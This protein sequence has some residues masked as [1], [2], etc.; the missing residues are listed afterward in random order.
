MNDQI[1]IIPTINQN[2]SNAVLEASKGKN[3]KVPPNVMMMVFLLLLEAEN[4]SSHSAAIQAK[5]LENNAFAQQRLNA[6][7]EKVQ[8]N[9]IP[10]EG[11]VYRTVRMTHWGPGGTYW[12]FK[13]VSVPG[14]YVN[15]TAVAEAEMKNQELMSMREKISNELI[16]LQQNS[17]VDTV[18]VNDQIQLTIMTIRKGSYIL[19]ILD[20]L[21]FKMLL[22][23]P[24]RF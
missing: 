16:V 11:K 15:A 8:W 23:S 9:E 7:A 22:R 3:V 17:K 18:T 6:E 10:K 24:P 4:I 21:T 5:D 14:A 1:N 19:Q 20:S 2:A 13:R 12:T